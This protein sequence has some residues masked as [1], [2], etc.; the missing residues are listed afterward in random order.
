MANDSTALQELLKTMRAEYAQQLPGK[1]QLI[2]A[3]WNSLLSDYNYED[4]KALHLQA[5]NL[6]GTA[7]TFGNVTL[8]NSARLLE[9]FLYDFLDVTEQKFN[10][11]NAMQRAEISNYVQ[12]LKKIA[13]I[14]SPNST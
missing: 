8:S 5:H 14:T 7:A 4:F 2:E 11:P 10:L 9:H 3:S 1:I 12:D 6:A 13:D